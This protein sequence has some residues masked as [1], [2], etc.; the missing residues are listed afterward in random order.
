MYPLMIAAI[1]TGDTPD[2]IYTKVKEVIGL[3]S[4][5]VVWTPSKEK[6]WLA[7]LVECLV[8]KNSLA[9]LYTSTVRLCQC[10]RRG[11]HRVR[12][13]HNSCHVWCLL[14]VCRQPYPLNRLNTDFVS[15]SVKSAI[16]GIVF[17]RTEFI[18]CVW[19][20][21]DHAFDLR[22]QCALR[23]E[24]RLVNWRWTLAGQMDIHLIQG[25]SRHLSSYSSLLLPYTRR[26]VQDLERDDLQFQF[27][28]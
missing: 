10:A 17:I 16:Y 4:G 2:D 24:Y 12:C 11:A 27:L 28:N 14:L 15:H 22:T 18:R 6:L 23:L 26:S 13:K 9:I 1:V 21:H 5:S 20:A 8:R 25:G 3:Q 7:C 19:C